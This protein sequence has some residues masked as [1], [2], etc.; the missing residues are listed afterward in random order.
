MLNACLLDEQ[1]ILRT[2]GQGIARLAGAQIPERN[3]GQAMASAFP[4]LPG[5]RDGP[6][7]ELL[8]HFK[9]EETE[10]RVFRHSINTHGAPATC[11]TRRWGRSPQQAG[12]GSL[13]SLVAD[14]TEDACMPRA[15]LSVSREETLGGSPLP[16]RLF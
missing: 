16:G 15:V 13:P 2:L 1:V 10:T 8:P 14:K 12:S 5:S 3:L 6:W 11:Q 9:E 7:E 4:V